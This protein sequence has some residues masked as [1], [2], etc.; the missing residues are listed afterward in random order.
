MA[1]IHPI[2][3][4]K[5]NWS[6]ITI[7]V[8]CGI[9]ILSQTPLKQLPDAPGSDKTHHLMAYAALAYP[10]S[11]RQ[12]TGWEAIIL[13]FALYSGLIE[14]I[15]PYMYRNGEWLDFVANITGLLLG[16]MLGLSTSKL[17]DKF[18]QS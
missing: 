14:I 11:L 12:P 1:A 4:I 16:G 3:L 13:L 18:D 15:Q 7:I 6:I 8:L 9:T 5:K 2:N 10:A 17:Q